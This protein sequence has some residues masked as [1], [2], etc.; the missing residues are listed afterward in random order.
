MKRERKGNI[1]C[2][3]DASLF[4]MKEF[5]GAKMVNAYAYDNDMYYIEFDNGLILKFNPDSIGGV[6]V[7]SLTIEE[8]ELGY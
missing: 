7:T 3:N 1:N 5:E 4:A 2:L 8:F 6:E